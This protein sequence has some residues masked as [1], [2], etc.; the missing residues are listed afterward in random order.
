NG[1]RIATCA[2]RAVRRTYPCRAGG[3]VWALPRPRR[4]RRAAGQDADG[5]WSRPASRGQAACSERRLPDPRRSPCRGRTVPRLPS[6][7]RAVIKR[8]S[9]RLPDE[10]RRLRP[11]PEAGVAMLLR[12]ADPP[13][14]PRQAVRLPNHQYGE[15]GLA[16]RL[17]LVVDEAQHLAERPHLGPREMM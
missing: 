2:P 4:G 3:R 17:G 11:L 7:S 1:R 16:Q 14:L 8:L 15:L 12:A 6:A 10:P 5:S 13:A 9:L